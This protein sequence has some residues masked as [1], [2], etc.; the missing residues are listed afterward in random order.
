MVTVALAGATTGFGLTMLKTFLHP[1][2]LN[3]G[4]HK[5]IVLS[6]S[7]QPDLSAQDV[8]VR[9][10]DYN[11]HSQLVNNLKDVHTILSLIGGGS[12]EALYSAQVALITAGVEAGVKRFA[13]SEYAGRGYE[14]ID[15]YE[16][17]ARVWEVVQQSGLE[18][19]RFE[20][21]LFM[22]VLATGTPKGM[23]EVGIR[24]GCKSGEEEALAGLRPWNFVIN[25]RA[26]TADFA[27]DGSGKMVLT[28]MRDVA[29]F[30]WEALSTERKW[31]PVMGMRGDVTSFKEIVRKLERVS[32]RKFLV[33]ENAIEVLEREA[34]EDPSKTFYNQARIA[35]AKGWAL[36]GDEMNM[37]YP[38]VKPV[39]VDEFI[40]KWWAGVELDAPSWE[41]DQ[42]FG[43]EDFSDK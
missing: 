20:C 19:T 41:V 10:T 38:L 31:E 8:E 14:G 33:R 11:N 13:P 22:S 23:T 29:R 40:E 26:G 39:S 12:P 35:M 43:V 18:Y 15:L 5:L 16:P 3:N 7:L 9:V 36:V 1:N 37:A 6:R 17:K 27:G 2:K 21:G 25:I 28:D 34:R 4:K 24:E 30:V 42:A 32:S